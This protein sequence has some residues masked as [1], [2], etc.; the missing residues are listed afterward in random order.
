MTKKL[1]WL[2]PSLENVNAGD[3][4]IAD[5]INEEV[6]RAT[7]AKRITTHRLLKPRELAQVG[8]AKTVFVGGTNIINSKLLYN[9]QWLM[10]AWQVALMWNKL[11]FVGS[12]WWQYQRE[13][14]PVTRAVFKGLSHPRIPH[15][16][17]DSFTAKRFEAM[18]IPAIMTGCPTMWGMHGTRVRLSPGRGS[19]VS[20]LTDYH[21]SPVADH[22]WLSLLASE[23]DEVLVV[24]MGPG[25][26]PAFHRLEGL[27]KNVRWYG[28]GAASLESARSHAAD[29]V[30]TRLH[31][32]IR[33]IQS[34]GGALIV[35]V[36][37]RA[38]E[39]GRDSGLPVI[40]RGDL[41]EL[42]EALDG[43]REWRIVMPIEEIESWRDAWRTGT[44]SL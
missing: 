31:A 1:L 30:G 38:T 32:A 43:D 35:S 19:V 16:V 5:A 13:P 23:Y 41:S 11:V 37:N 39:I 14:Y 10:P 27:P 26:E 20:T 3:E 12:G 33:W 36:D 2:D 34:G 21:L 15:A 6:F 44:K 9:G 40:S 42:E 4:I 7:E 8:S 29:F 18:G 22:A 17:R 28:F 24:G 25:D